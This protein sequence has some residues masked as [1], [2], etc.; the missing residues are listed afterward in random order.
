MADTVNKSF[1]DAL[2]DAKAAKWSAGV[3]FDR[4]NPLPLDQWSV[5]KDKAAAEAYLTNAK[6]YPGQ[7]I[8]YAEA[9][10][11]DGETLVKAGG[12]VACVLSS[13][14]AG[15][16][17]ELKQ[18]GVI[19]TGAG[20]INVTE[21]GEISVAV[22]DSTIKIVDNK[23]TAV[24]PDFVDT[25]TTYSVKD[26]EKVLKLEG[27]EFSTELGL[28][29]ENGK[30][31]LTGKDGVVIAEF[32]DAD[33]I[34]DGVLEDVSYNEETKDLVF[35]WNIV[36]G[37]DEEGNKIYKTDTVNIADLID[38]NT[39]TTYEISANGVSVTLTPSE[40][41][42]TTVTL[43]AYTKSEAD[44]KIDE[45]IASVTG[46]ESA[47]DVKLALE[48]YRDALNK[49]VWGDSAGEWTTSKTEDGKTVVTYTPAYGTESRIDKLEKVG[50]QANV[51][52]EIKVNGAKVD[53]VNKSVDI[54]VPTKTSQLTNDSNFV[55][56]VK[57]RDASAEAGYTP[58]LAINRAENVVT[59]DDEALQNT[60][61]AVKTTADSAVQSGEF[62]GKAMSKDGTKLSISQADAR[63]ALGLKS[64]AY[65]DSI[66]TGVMSVTT[67]SANGTISVDGSDVAVKGLGSA[68]YTDST[69]YDAAGSAAKVLGLNT[70]AATAATVHGARNLAASIL[71]SENDGAGAKTV[72]GAHAAVTALAEGAVKTNTEA[73]AALNKDVNT[74]GSVAHTAKAAADTAVT[75]LINN[76]Q[77]KTNTDAIATLVGTDANKSARAIA[78]EEVALIVGAAPEAM[79]TLEEVAKWIADDASGAAAMVKDIKA[80]A[81]AIAAIN[82]ESTGILALAKA[83]SDSN[84]AAAKKYTDDSIEALR[85]SIH[86][87]DDKTIKL[88]ESNNAYVAEVSTDVLVQGYQELVLCAGDANGYHTTH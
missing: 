42:A 74:A 29:H 6:A 56:N 22:D 14:A 19:P 46:G 23:L 33:F 40:G 88:N 54:T 63:E 73:I 10:V 80:N 35:T 24:I 31:S 58:V 44:S 83:H 79:D 17:L 67:G 85:T 61:K 69:A 78:K 3:A 86:G 43:D 71:G 11:K 34:A 39:D 21:N 25:D 72:Y 49:E 1:F 13:N 51:I 81:D 27:T 62:A 53:P 84:L 47:A 8:A 12:M 32:S 70:D 65:E 38:V 7:V 77:V 15:T 48:S 50:A 82:N 9:D 55:V 5:F 76:G 60:I 57:M 18:I 41:E 64:L 36:T 45:K 52:E 4:S 26:G 16:G 28:K 59:V 66:D 30:I 75:N 37:E 87:V 20:A 2:L 68:A